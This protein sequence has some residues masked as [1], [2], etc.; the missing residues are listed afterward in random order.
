MDEYDDCF[1][2][3]GDNL[4]QQVL[5]TQLHVLHCN[6]PSEEL[7]TKKNGKKIRCCEVYA[8]SQ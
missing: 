6:L 5:A 3:Y 1:T 8:V 7:Q 2:L 4:D